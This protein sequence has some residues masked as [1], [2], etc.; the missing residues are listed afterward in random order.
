MVLASLLK[1]IS[2]LFPSI[3]H[4]ANLD[5][6][7]DG[8]Y[9]HFLNNNQTI[10]H[11]SIIYGIRQLTEIEMIQ[12]CTNETFPRPV[13]TKLF[14]FTSNYQLRIYQ[15]ACFYFDHNHQWQSDGLIVSLARIIV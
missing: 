4:S 9:V 15:S 5:R 12:F 11:H 2:L 6:N 10:N 8:T 13:F 3:D 7:N 14:R 1:V